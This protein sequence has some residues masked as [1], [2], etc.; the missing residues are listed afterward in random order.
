[1]EQL[2]SIITYRYGTDL[3]E[4]SRDTNEMYYDHKMTPGKYRQL[5]IKH[6]KNNSCS[7]CHLVTHNIDKCTKS[8]LIF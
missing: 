7:R 1:M 2:N 5:V 3:L 8:T 4:L 6:F